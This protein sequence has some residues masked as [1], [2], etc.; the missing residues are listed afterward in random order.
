MVMRYQHSTN[1]DTFHQV[2]EMYNTTKPIVSK[3]HPLH[4]DI[5]PFGPRTRKWERV[6]K[7]S[8]NCY[9]LMDGGSHDG[10][11]EFAPI[12][13]TY[14][15]TRERI[16]IRNE[17]GAYTH[18]IRNTMLENAVPSNMQ[19]YCRNG[20]QY[21][22]SSRRNHDVYYLPK[23]DYFLE[24]EREVN[25]HLWHICSD[26][27]QYV[28]PKKRVDKKLKAKIKPYSDKLLEYVVSM[29]NILPSTD[30]DYFNKIRREY[31]T[32]DYNFTEKLCDPDNY[33]QL[34]SMFQEDMWNYLRYR[35]GWHERDTVEN[36]LGGDVDL[37]TLR[38]KYNSFINKYCALIDI[39][40]GS[41]KIIKREETK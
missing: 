34:T 16:R 20:K 5:R 1:L 8:Y 30:D 9:G 29:Y 22:T 17:L 35:K 36:K 2:E 7:F 24:F 32:R 28:H 12:L 6:K 19:F 23:G 10:L 26:T 15:G 38:A 21:I 27:Y 31:S 3:K 33:R 25:T 39:D 13:W 40:K 11:K 41:A 14:D 4:H 18:T 37:P